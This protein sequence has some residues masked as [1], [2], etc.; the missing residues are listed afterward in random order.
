MGLECFAI[1]RQNG[2]SISKLVPMR[3]RFFLF[4][5]FIQSRQVFS[6]LTGACGWF[7]FSMF[8]IFID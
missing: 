5:F 7:V 6:S 8:T 3:R 2:N 4:N 1:Y